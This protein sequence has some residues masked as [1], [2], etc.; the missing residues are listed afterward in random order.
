M[1]K[2][3]VIFKSFRSIVLFSK[4]IIIDSICHLTICNQSGKYNH[5][6]LKRTVNPVL[7]GHSKKDKTKVLMTIASS[8]KDECIAKCSPWSILQ[9]I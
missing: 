5:Q 7:S 1:C 4:Y 9:Y 2:I 3:L 8:M 6:N